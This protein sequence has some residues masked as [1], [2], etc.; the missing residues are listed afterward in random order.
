MAP[1]SSKAVQEAARKSLPWNQLSQADRRL[2]HYMVRNTSVFRRMPTR[3][4]RCRPDVF[5]LLAQRPEV[6]AS[7]WNVMGVSQLQV[8]R[9][10]NSSFRAADQA[11]TQGAVRVLHANWGADA[12][13]EMLVYAEG[14]YEA[15]PL[16][17]PIK[18]R[19][20]LY[21]RS[22]STVEEN[23]ET[24]VTAR[25]DSFIHFE[26]ASAN[27][28]AK[29]L[30]PLLHRTADHNFVETMKFVSTFSRTTEQNPSGVARLAGRLKNIDAGARAE[31]VSLCRRTGDGLQAQTPPAPVV[32][33]ARG[34]S[35]R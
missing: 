28:I 31:L 4:I 35:P 20:L 10:S 12:R 1:S 3:V 21:L 11:G 22:A 29:T 19:S 33:V 27:F 23:G 5:T 13:N 9:V 7:I 26:R 30:Q 34:Q 16:P 25:L 18:A 8:T 14:V 2:A 24:Y 15:K 6:V 32:R 17:R